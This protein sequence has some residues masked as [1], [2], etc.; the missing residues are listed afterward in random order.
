LEGILSLRKKKILLFQGIFA[1]T[2]ED[3]GCESKGKNRQ[4]LVERDPQLSILL[5]LLPSALRVSA[6]KI[7][8]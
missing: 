8:K 5:M 1:D 3:S 4:T 2:P 6:L 7:S